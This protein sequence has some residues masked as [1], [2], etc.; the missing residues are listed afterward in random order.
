MR[1]SELAKLSGTNAPT[2]RYYEQIGLLPQA[3]RQ[4]GSQRV[5][6]PADVRRLTFIRRC[7]E[8]G[9]PLE[10]VRV[11]AGLLQDRDRSCLHARELAHDHLADVRERLRQLRELERQVATF[12]RECDR[13][14]AGGPGAECAVLDELARGGTGLE[15]LPRVRRRTRKAG[16]A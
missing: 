1:I 15:A 5:Y 16:A 4:G 10:Q 13:A 8:L 14:C 7:R 12:V 11:L 3:P 6:E 9:F 2:I